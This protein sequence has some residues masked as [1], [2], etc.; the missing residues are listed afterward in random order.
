MS[1]CS[2]GALTMKQQRI[3][4]QHRALHSLIC[5]TSERRSQLIPGDESQ[6]FVVSLIPI[7]VPIIVS[8]CRHKSSVSWYGACSTS[9]TWL[10]AHYGISSAPFMDHDSR[11][12]NLHL[13]ESSRPH[14]C[15]RYSI[16]TRP[17]PACVRPD[18][19]HSL[20]DSLKS[21]FE[22]PVPEDPGSNMD[23]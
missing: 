19:L 16:L 5:L 13:P 6:G 3:L 4:C 2:K 9:N 18:S 23:P 7:S 12:R 22:T 15:K 1:L 20:P 14:R 21:S 8:N 11:S 10:A 17:K